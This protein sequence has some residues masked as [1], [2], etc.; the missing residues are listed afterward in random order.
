MSIPSES[1]SGK[2]DDLNRLTDNLSKQVKAAYELSHSGRYQ[3][4]RHFN[5]DNR[6]L[7]RK[8]FTESIRGT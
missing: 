6:R 1:L 3:L 8:A 5:W 7:Q 2:R 4:G